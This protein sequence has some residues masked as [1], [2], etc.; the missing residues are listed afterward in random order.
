M[1]SGR[2]RPFDLL[3]TEPVSP[4]ANLET[5]RH[6]AEPGADRRPG[7]QLMA[8]G[9]APV[10]PRSDAAPALS[11]LLLQDPPL[12]PGLGG[13]ARSAF[14]ST[15]AATADVRT[16]EHASS[17]VQQVVQAMHLQWRDGLGE[18]RIVL[19]PPELGHLRVTLKVADGAVRAA[20]HAAAADVAGWIESQRD[21][22]K[23]A[24]A[25]AGLQLEEL[26][27]DADGRQEHAAR[28]QQHA[29]RPPRRWRTGGRTFD[30][31]A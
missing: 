6:D 14:A 3:R 16:A 2:I 21:Q 27:V 20:V 13:L 19:T 12:S 18:A 25:D 17:V 30:L 24:L 10:V 9:P 31:S 4:D 11:A 23:S 22:L 8:G 26:V 1:Q 28:D 7:P 29:P 15:L 5:S